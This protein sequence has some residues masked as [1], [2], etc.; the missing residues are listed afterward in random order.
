MPFTYQINLGRRLATTMFYG[1][2]TTDD[3]GRYVSDLTSDPDWRPGFH[4]LVDLSSAK[5]IRIDYVG[6]VSQAAIT[7]AYR[8]AIGNGRLAV[9]APTDH[10]FA[11]SRSYLAMTDDLPR[12]AAVF[13]NLRIAESWLALAI[14]D[15]VVI[16]ARE[17]APVVVEA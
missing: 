4:Q 17:P 8:H 6:T 3:F 5:A 7:S 14:S 15:S 13:R 1:I 16:D 10:A 2:V 11:A 12:S 9:V